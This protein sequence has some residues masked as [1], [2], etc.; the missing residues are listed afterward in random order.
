M[1]SYKWGYKSPNMGY[2]YGYPVTLLI[3]P[4]ITTHEPPSRVIRRDDFAFRMGL[5]SHKPLHRHRKRN[6]SL[7]VRL[8][9]TIALSAA[10]GAHNPARDHPRAT[11]GPDTKHTKLTEQQCLDAEA[12]CGLRRGIRRVA[13]GHPTPFRAVCPASASKARDGEGVKDFIARGGVEVEGFKVLS[14]CRVIFAFGFNGKELAPALTE[15]LGLLVECE[16]QRNF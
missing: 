10:Y 13:C 11:P 6:C 15:V 4:L 5:C 12:R 3:T 16:C 7:Q 9:F 14:A 2:N 8:P 1:D